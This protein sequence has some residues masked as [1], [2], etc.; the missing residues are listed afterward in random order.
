M[1]L[2]LEA[3]PEMRVIVLAGVGKAFCAGGDVTGMGRG[4]P[5]NRSLGDKI[6]GLHQLRQTLMAR[7]FEL[8]KPTTAVVPGAAFCSRLGNIYENGKR[9][10]PHA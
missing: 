4:G 2:V 3:D 10:N 8:R 9:S 1:L 7:L 6:R 5:D